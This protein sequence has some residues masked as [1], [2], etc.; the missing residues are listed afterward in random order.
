MYVPAQDGYAMYYLTELD[1]RGAMGLGG[2]EELSLGSTRSY[3]AAIDY[4]TGKTAWR[5]VYPTPG[6]TLGPGM[7][8]T[9]GTLLFA[10]DVDGNLVAYDAT[11][12]DPLWH[13]EMGALVSNAP[14]TYLAD[15]HQYVLAAAGD[16][17]YAF[18]LP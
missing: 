7:M 9:A 2:K 15:G 1:P 5:H 18:R 11:D 14:E 3:I 10:G 6:G 17:L 4:E 8:T 12:G 13:A 16:T